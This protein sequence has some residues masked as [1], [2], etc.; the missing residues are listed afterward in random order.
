MSRATWNNVSDG[1]SR[2]LCV[3]GMVVLKLTPDCWLKLARNTHTLFELLGGEIYLVVSWYT[4][5]CFIIH[6]HHI[7]HFCVPRPKFLEP[8]WSQPVK[9]TIN[10]SLIVI[11]NILL[12][13][14]LYDSTKLFL[15]FSTSSLLSAAQNSNNF[16]ESKIA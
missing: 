9:S 15:N 12:A 16:V 5:V 13:T 14:A 10:Y 6:I 3:A 2:W 4:L 7:L 11:E 8:K 1:N